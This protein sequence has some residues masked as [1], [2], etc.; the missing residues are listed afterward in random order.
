M[1]DFSLP[2]TLMGSGYTQIGPPD[3]WIFRKRVGN[4]FHQFRMDTGS[5]IG[6]HNPHVSHVHFEIL[7]LTGTGAPLATNHIIVIP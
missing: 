3:R 6:N 7:N 1:G 5:L 2:V 4:E